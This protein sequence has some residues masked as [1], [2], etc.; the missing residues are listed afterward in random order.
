M[1]LKLY[2]IML[3][4]FLL[5][6]F[7]APSIQAT[8]NKNNQ[9]IN[10]GHKTFNIPFAPVPQTKIKI[11]YVNLKDNI[12][13]IQALAAEIAAYINA[14]RGKIDVIITPESNTIAIAYAVY[15]KTK[16]PYIVLTK[17]QRPDMGP[18]AISVPVKSI[19]TAGNQTLWIS[20]DNIEA[21]KGKKV[22]ILDDVVSTGNTLAAM[23]ELVGMAGGKLILNPLVCFC[24]GE[25]R[26]DVTAVSDTVLPVIPVS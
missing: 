20:E 16:I 4:I 2:E 11:L 26:S 13:L 24:E 5:T 7:F 18:K 9:K 25:K 19:T 1:T 15:E 23:K 21:I 17:K 3:G 14:N 22:L 10:V 8:T 6:G 12:E